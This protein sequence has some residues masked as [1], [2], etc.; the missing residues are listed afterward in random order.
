MS[1][2]AFGLSEPILRAVV[3]EGYTTPTPIQSQAI[4]HVLAGRDLLGCAQT[5]TGKTA[6]FALPILHRLTDRGNPPKGAGRRIRVLVLTPTRE[7]AAQ[8]A[9]SFRAYGRNTAL[10]QAVVFGGVGQNPQVRAL[11][12]GIDIL[13]AT[14]GRLLDLINQGYV[15][16]RAVETFVLDEADRMLDMG[17]L[18]DVRRIIARLPEKRQTLFFSATMPPAI[19]QLAGAILRDPV[20]VRIAPVQA[21]T[22]LIEQS[23]CFVPKHHKPQLLAKLLAKK[24]VTR[25]IVFTRT[26]RGADRVARHLNQSGIRAEAMHG[27]KSQSARERTFASFK[28]SRPPILVATDLA[29]RGIDVDGISHIFNFDLPHEP[30]TYVHRIGRTGRAGATGTA[31]SFCDHEERP[32]LKDIE[33]LIRRTLDVDQ[34]H[35]VPA[36]AL[37]PATPSNGSHRGSRHSRGR[38]NGHSQP[39][40][41]AHSG[42]GHH[43]SGRP[44][45]GSFFGR[46][47]KKRRHA[48]ALRT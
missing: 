10:R 47:R 24:P 23:V 8:I 13:V 9:E 3:A 48:H 38:S 27:N 31:I 44:A 15:D 16:F 46:R 1:F 37:P 14:P 43:P 30:E 19:E 35:P 25:A 18:P 28:S 7:L 21:T 12:H 5:G 39:R 34:D 22:E 42:N 6:A 29:A 20:R 40:H 2:H 32:L 41:P 4:P 11:K 36:S 33:R 17:F 45:G 26:K